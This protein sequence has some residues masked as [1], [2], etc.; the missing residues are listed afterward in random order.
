MKFDTVIFDLD[1]TL[2]NTAPDLLRATNHVLSKSGRAAISLDQMLDTVSFGARQMIKRGFEVTGNPADDAAMDD[3]F[4]LFIE[5]YLANIAVDSKP[6]DGCIDFLAKCQDRGMKMGVC[7][8]KYKAP[9][10]KL[11]TELDMIKYFGAVVGPDTIN[12]AKPDPA[13]YLET[14]NRIGGNLKSSIMIGDSKTDILTAKAAGVPVVA[15][16]FGYS[17][18]PIEG[19]GADFVLGHYDEMW[20]IL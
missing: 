15:F 14:V 17:D 8:N 13:P 3:Y 18:E 19:L 9:S 6:F 20:K 11:L 5:Y 1:G 7:T 4:A 16:T 2:V 10:V 12:K